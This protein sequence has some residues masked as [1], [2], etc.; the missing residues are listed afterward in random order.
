VK[1]IQKTV[2]EFMA[3]KPVMTEIEARLKYYRVCTILLFMQ[4]NIIKLMFSLAQIFVSHFKFVVK[5]H[6]HTLL[7]FDALHVI[8]LHNGRSFNQLLVF[9][10]CADS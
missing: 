10:F 4:L 8:G 5:Q 6:F 3:T 2:D 9:R 1:E 7:S